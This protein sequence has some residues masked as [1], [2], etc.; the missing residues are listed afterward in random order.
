MRGLIEKDLRLT[1]SR[2]RT[3]LVFF[4]VALIMGISTEGTF[5]VGY[6]TMFSII[7]AIGTMSYDEFDNGFAFLMTLPFSRKS[8]V[9]EKYLFSLVLALAAWILGIIFYCIGKVVKQEALDFQELL[10]MLL[11]IMPLIYLMAP[12]M[13]PLQLKFGSEKSRIVLFVLFGILAI[14][15]FGSSKISGLQDIIASLMALISGLSP[16]ILFLAALAVTMLLT[17]ISYLLSI[18][19][20]A[21]KEF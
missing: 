4:V 2:K 16:L 5:I 8:Y 15:L 10:P 9:R 6:L 13:I 1:F 17:F 20:M 18:R 11:T 7:V 12:L 21:K 14:L 3:L 19:I